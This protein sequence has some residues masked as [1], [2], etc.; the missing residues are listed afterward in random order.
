M[1]NRLES[2]TATRD[3]PAIWKRR[4]CNPNDSLSMREVVIIA[5]EV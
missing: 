2:C 1:L 5:A 4:R 3:R